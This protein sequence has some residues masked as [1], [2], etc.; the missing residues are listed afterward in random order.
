MR[1]CGWRC[2]Q[3]DYRQPK[4][5]PDR[6]TEQAYI[7]FRVSDASLSFGD[8]KNS[9]IKQ[10]RDLCGT[11]SPTGPPYEGPFLFVLYAIIVS[12]TGNLLQSHSWEHYSQLEGYATFWRESADY[13]FLAILHHTALGAYLFCPYG[14]VLNDKDPSTALKH[15]L[16]AL[17][18]LAKAHGAFFVRIEPT[19]AFSASEMANF[20]LKK[21]HD[22]DPAHT[23]I[24]D[25]TQPLDDIL[26]PMDKNKTRL[27]RQRDAKG[28]TIR[29]TSDPAEVSVLTDL[30]LDVSQRNHFTPQSAQHLENQLRSGFATLYIAEITPTSLAYLADA[31]SSLRAKANSTTASSPTEPNSQASPSDNA[32]RVPI[33]AAIVYDYGGIRYYAHAAADDAY[34]KLMVGSTLLVQMI[35]DAKEQGAHTF[36]FW[37]ITTSEDP[38]HPWYGF[39]KFKKSFGGEMVEYSGTWDLPLNKFKYKLYGLLRK[40]NRRTR[41]LHH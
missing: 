24:I 16:E 11:R 9:S 19:Y 40:L 32:P 39:T 37:G 34:R 26:K 10:Y 18:T 33:A 30:L 3:A 12:M 25:L 36:D 22:L 38:S 7:S 35:V 5:H 29:S 2:A 15:A 6:R 41:R 28:L 14:P 20:G 4:R 23:W 31:P 8:E 1:V 27:W 13:Q 17:K 21:S